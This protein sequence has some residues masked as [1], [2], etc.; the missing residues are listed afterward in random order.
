MF[1]ISFDNSP[2]CGRV[3]SQWRHGVVFN[4]QTFVEHL[5]CTGCCAWCWATGGNQVGVMVLTDTARN[6][7]RKERG[8][9]EIP[10]GQNPEWYKGES[11]GSVIVQKGGFGIYY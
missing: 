10:F 2:N 4:Q 11:H 6:K 3:E 1:V 8:F 5:L 9:E 7:V